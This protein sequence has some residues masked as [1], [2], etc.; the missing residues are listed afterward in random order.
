M[1]IIY[2][3]SDFK[4]T[5][6]KETIFTA[7]VDVLFGN[8]KKACRGSGICRLST[9][10]QNTRNEKEKPAAV[11]RKGKGIL[12]SYP[13]GRLMLSVFKSSLCLRAIKGSF[14]RPYF[15]VEE[16]FKAT[17]PISDGIEYLNVIILPGKY[18]LKE[19]EIGYHIDFTLR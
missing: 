6:E 8:P 9:Q 2:G 18:P 17:L 10:Y 5:T 13:D 11:C 7:R 19:T 12:R 15:T 3:E 14:S 1:T 16:V 4:I